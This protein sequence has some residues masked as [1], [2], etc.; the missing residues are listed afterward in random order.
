MEPTMTI[1]LAPAYQPG[2]HL[3][4]LVDDLRDTAPGARI[5]VVD[6]GS[7]P[8]SARVLDAVRDRGCTVL[9]HERNRGK[10][11]ALKTGFR[12][13]EQAYPGEDVVCADADGQHHVAD[14]LRVAEH[15]R[16]TGHTALG[17]RRFD[18]K[19]PLRSRFGNTVTRLLFHAATGRPVQDTQTGL[20][21][22][23]AHLLGWLQ[24]V[25]GERF[26]YEMNVLLTAARAGH[27]IDEITIA[28][29]YLDDNASSHFGSLTDSVRIYRPLLRF[30]G[31][32]LLAYARS[33]R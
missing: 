23:P 2:D 28:T 20:R 9:R 24:S 27:P 33:G 22:Y 7:A 12:Y 17:V 16:A 10:G 14:I 32:S 19:V 5:V 25:P 8:A 3:L 29:T 21:A 15:C 1:V 13:I 18:G 26:E 4:T 6:D 11:A 30:A 31:A